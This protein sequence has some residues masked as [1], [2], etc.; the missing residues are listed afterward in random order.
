M[1]CTVKKQLNVG[2][3][4]NKDNTKKADGLRCW[5]SDLHALTPKSRNNC[6]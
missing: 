5:T 3:S 2:F 6:L 4:G 1:Y